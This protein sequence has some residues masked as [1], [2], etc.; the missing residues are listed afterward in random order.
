[1]RTS[2]YPVIALIVIS[3]I[4]FTSKSSGAAD[5]FSSSSIGEAGA[6]AEV[7]SSAFT[8]PIRGLIPEIA[9]ITAIKIAAQ[10]LAA[11]L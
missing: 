7:G 11:C 3:S 9:I 5:G 4:G 8:F 1:M 10:A 2:L 6:S